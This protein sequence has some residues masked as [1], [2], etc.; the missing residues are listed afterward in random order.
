MMHS[1]GR[2]MGVAF[3]GVVPFVAAIAY[4]VATSSSLG[5]FLAVFSIAMVLLLL[6]PLWG[7]PV[8]FLGL[9]EARF[10][11][12]WSRDLSLVLLG[13]SVGGL[14]LGVSIAVAALRCEERIR[15]RVLLSLAYAVLISGS[16][17]GGVLTVARD[18]PAR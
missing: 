18:I 4:M 9:L 14:V 6:A 15:R 7:Y 11:E 13:V 5:Y 2:D 10:W 8:T 17:I 3:L 1:L 16:A 12:P